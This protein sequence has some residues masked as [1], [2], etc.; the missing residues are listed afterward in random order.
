LDNVENKGKMQHFVSFPDKESG[1]AF[2]ARFGDDD[3][4]W[5]HPYDT[6]KSQYHR[7]DNQRFEGM[8]VL[9]KFYPGFIAGLLAHLFKADVEQ[10]SDSDNCYT[11]KAD[12]AADI[13]AL[14]SECP[15]LKIEST[16]RFLVETLCPLRFVAWYLRQLLKERMGQKFYKFSCNARKCCYVKCSD[17][18]VAERAKRWVYHECFPKGVVKFTGIKVKGFTGGRRRG[19]GPV[20]SGGRTPKETRLATFLVSGSKRS[21]RQRKQNRQQQN[22]RQNRTAPVREEAAA[23]PITDEAFISGLAG[24][25]LLR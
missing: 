8:T 22:R 2:C 11:V 20:G 13:K 4:I 23:Q 16:D 21:Q 15:A 19:G 12:V 10:S 1:D 5:S 6:D 3:T 25:K 18:K 7:R 17:E 14:A 24:L 9:I